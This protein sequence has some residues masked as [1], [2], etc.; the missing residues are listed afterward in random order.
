MRIPLTCMR[1]FKEKGEPSDLFYPAELQD[2]GL[3]RME[4]GFG[5]R[6]ITC[7][8]EQ[9]FE[10]L[11]ELG[12]NAIVD[13]YYRESVSSFAS[14]FELFAEFYLRVI[15]LKCGVPDDKFL[16]AWKTIAAQS[17]RRLGAY[18]FVYLMENG[19]PPPLLK[20]KLIAFRNDV[21]HKG[22]IPT[23]E[24]AVDY[25]QSALD[26]MVPILED[27]KGRYTEHVSAVVSQHVREIRAQIEEPEL[28]SFMTIPTTISIS[29]AVAEPQL[30]LAQTLTRLTKSRHRIGGSSL[31]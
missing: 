28:V 22:R 1:C 6:T 25:G 3:Y 21:M 11:F 15:R 26:I 18:V 16:N 27:L 4:C 19:E 31:G 13:T 29:S 5:H 20:P 8:Q 23:R 7:L 12:A 10:I 9:K 14:S 17:E 24:Q 2:N 30:N